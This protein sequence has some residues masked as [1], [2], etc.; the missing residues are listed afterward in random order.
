MSKTIGRILP[1]IIGAMIFMIFALYNGYPMVSGDTTT[2]LESGFDLR[3]PHE[4]PVF[5]GLFILISSLGMSAWLT[6]FV[7]CLILSYLSIR[8]IKLV[9]GN[10][11]I[12]H[13]LALLLIISMGTIS[14]WY[15]SQLLPDIFTPIL[16]LASFLYL[17]AKNN[18][19][20]TILL[21]LIIYISIVV[22]YSHYV[23]STLFVIVVFL[24]SFIFK[25]QLRTV[26]A[27]TFKLGVITIIAWVSLFTSNYIAGNGFV[28]S[29]AS[30]VFLMGKLAESG[31]LDKYLEKACPKYN[32]TI[33]QYK[34]NIPPVAWEFVWDQ[35]NSAV[36]KAGGWEATKEEYSRII[37]DIA[38]RPKYWPFLA[39][40]SMEAT[41]R[42]VILTNIDE[43]DER[44]WIKFE[45]DSHVYKTI[46]RIFPH[47]INEFE[48]TR[49]N[50]KRFN[51]VFYD[52]VYV[53][54]F[55]ISLLAC[56]F[57]LNGDLRKQALRVYA[58]VVLYIFLNAFATA[59]FG[60]VL[61][62]LNSRNIWLLPMT[63]V[64]FL[65]KYF[66]ERYGSGLVD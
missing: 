12:E 34:D 48:V 40:K 3:V 64:I 15:A 37:R 29:R 59:T 17:R 31:V 16:F 44:P 13:S 47:E 19:A 18:I 1:T 55:L 54:L 63:N 33:C 52:E 58:L 4:R 53:I 30:H 43:G 21:I 7:Q 28:T 25:S 35:E 46:H 8:F 36:F 2:Y 38:S 42:Q 49:Q 61:T 22:H 45:E 26:R 27:K 60:N 14:S 11:R 51:L 56:M 6:I 57:L 39:F 62:R 66:R 41:F 23:I 20:H 50:I 24:S 65:Y 10:I 32:Y 5:Y 9:I